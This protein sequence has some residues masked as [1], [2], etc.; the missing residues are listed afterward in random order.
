MSSDTYP[1]ITTQTMTTRLRAAVGAWQHGPQRFMEKLN[2]PATQRY[3][4]RYLEDFFAAPDN[5][6]L[7]DEAGTV[8]LGVHALDWDS[9]LF[10]MKMAALEFL[11]S[12][13]ELRQ[14][15]RAAQALVAAAVSHARVRGVQFLASKVYTDDLAMIHAVQAQGF[16]LVDTVLDYVCEL[17]RAHWPV[18]CDGIAVRAAEPADCEAVVA[19]YRNAFSGHFG[20]FHADPNF[21]SEQANSVYEQWV[22]SSFAG[23]A[24][25][26]AV[27]EDHGEIIGATLWKNTSALE[28]A[29]GLDLAHYSIGAVDPASFGKGVFTSTTRKGMEHFRGCARFIE[30]PTHVNNYG[31]QQ[32]YERLGWKIRDARHTFHLWL[33]ATAATMA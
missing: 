31:V 27:A 24:D 32:G 10:G 5:I 3:W 18:D 12:D 30:G 25:Y 2:A 15:R 17:E 16:L 29:C 33:N 28:T 21:S 26:I 14:R 1:V 23:F 8:L 4:S 22:R 9:R 6:G 19:V 20:R 7:S 13:P 11:L